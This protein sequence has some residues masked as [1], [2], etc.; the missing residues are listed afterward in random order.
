MTLLGKRAVPD[1]GGHPAIA[2]GEQFIDQ[3]LD[4]ARRDLQELGIGV[5]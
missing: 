1:L 3:R 2:V 4:P 5:E